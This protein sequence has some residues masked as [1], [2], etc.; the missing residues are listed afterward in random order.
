MKLRLTGL[1]SGVRVA[2]SVL[3]DAPSVTIAFWSGAGS[4][5]ESLRLSG[6]SHFVEHMLFK[7]TRRRSAAQISRAIEGRGGDLNAFTQEENACY[8]ARVPFDRAGDAL[9][10]LADMYVHS[11]FDPHDVD[12]ERDVIVEEI[13]MYR[14]QAHH[15]VQEMLTAALWP[16]HALGRPVTG[17]PEGLSPIGEHELR[18]FQRRSHCAAGTV[19]AVAGRIEHAD[20]CRLVEG[21]LAGIPRARRPA[22]QRADACRAPRRVDIETRPVQQTQLALGF[23]IFGRSDPRRFALRVLN[24]VV[25]EN[26]SSRLFQVL[27][28]RNGLAYSVHSSFHLFHETGCMV[29]SAGTER[30]RCMRAADAIVKELRRVKE[31]RVGTPELRRAKD[32]V[33]GQFRL[34]FE[35]TSNQA[36]WLGESVATL[37]RIVNPEQT[38]EGLERVTADDVQRVARA[39]FRASGASVAAIGPE[40]GRGAAR[41]FRAV[42]RRL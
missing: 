5:H 20:V 15:A 22:C 11:R 13:M 12:L 23:R 31:R 30:G 9:D 19:V 21:Q 2:T 39:V 41:E 35:S 29:V 24:A 38:V 14:D 42:L 34:G 32:Y 1:D 10:V 3:P 7:G 25:G 28:E 40:M 37:G 4:R 6:V 17:T 36:M 18:A 33:I 8:Y 16:D 26:M 27:R